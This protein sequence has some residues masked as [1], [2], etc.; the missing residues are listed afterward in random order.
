MLTVTDTKGCKTSDSIIVDNVVPVIELADG[1]HIS[2]FPNP[3]G[4][5]LIVELTLLDVSPLE[6]SLFSNDGKLVFRST[7]VV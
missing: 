6:F 2:V 7:K 4:S 1:S 5:S 3:F